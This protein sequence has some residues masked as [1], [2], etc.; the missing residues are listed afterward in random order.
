[1]EYIKGDIRNNQMSL[2]CE[3]CKSIIELL[4]SETIPSTHHTQSLRKAVTQCCGLGALGLKCD[5]FIKEIFDQL[6]HWDVMHT[7]CGYRYEE[8][9]F[10]SNY[11]REILLPLQK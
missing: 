7:F 1:M 4:N 6:D 10:L 11:I 3:N 8:E 2:P 5:K 9:W